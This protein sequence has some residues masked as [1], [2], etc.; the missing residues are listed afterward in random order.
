[1]NRQVVLWFK[2]KKLSFQDIEKIMREL[3]LPFSAVE[4]AVPLPLPTGVRQ[5]NDA[6]HSWSLA[7]VACILAPR[8][9]ASLDVGLVCQFAVVHDLAEIHT[10]DITTFDPDERHRTKE[11]LEHHAV[12][13]IAKDFAD[14]SWL[15]DQLEAYERQDTA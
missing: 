2:M 15:V 1:M 3:V 14:F 13:K 7:F 6:E 9:D 4:R 11:E 8:V 5:E 12:Q 10:G